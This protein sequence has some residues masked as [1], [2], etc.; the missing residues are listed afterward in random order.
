MGDYKNAIEFINRAIVHDNGNATLL[1]HLGDVYYKMA[2][3]EKAIELWENSLKM[4]STNT[5]IPIK[6]EKGID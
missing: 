3:K 6:I 4:D 2:D 5:E 1:D